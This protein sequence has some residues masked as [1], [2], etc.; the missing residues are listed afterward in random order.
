MKSIVIHSG[1]PYG[2]HYYAYIKDDLK[3]GNWN[4]NLPE[5]FSDTPSEVD[6]RPA[7]V[8]AKE[9]EEKKKEENEK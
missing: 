6:D 1:G 8:K 4:V 9:A 7:H 3:E 5:K 2:G